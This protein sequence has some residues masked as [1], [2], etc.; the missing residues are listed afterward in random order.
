MRACITCCSGW[1][2]T[3]RPLDSS[4]HL[5]KPCPQQVPEVRN[6]TERARQRETEERD[7]QS[8]CN[9]AMPPYPHV[10]GKR[11][12]HTPQGK[13]ISSSS[14]CAKAS[15]RISRRPT[16]QDS[17]TFTKEMEQSLS[18]PST[19][20]LGSCRCLNS[21]T[22]ASQP[23]CA[24]NG[25]PLSTGRLCSWTLFT[26]RSALTSTLT[27]RTRGALVPLHIA[28]AQFSERRALKLVSFI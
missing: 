27:G 3:T 16:A 12:P 5:L 28:R 9:G 6:R 22:C 25:T 20:I 2:T 26:S 4:C 14:T 23:W 21:P 15:L 19:L 11:T 1:R 18:I 17:G 7:S 13:S 24:R 10:H 8:T